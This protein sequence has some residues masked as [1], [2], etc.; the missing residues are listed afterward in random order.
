MIRFPIFTTVS[1][2]CMVDSLWE[3]STTVFPALS[4]FNDFR[5][6]P[7]LRGVQI[8]GGFVKEHQ[9]RIVKKSPWRCRSSAVRHRKEYPPA[10][11][12]PSHNLLRSVM[13]NSSTEA[14]LAASRISFMDAPELSDG[15]IGRDGNRETDGV[16]WV[17]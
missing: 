17:T 6:I 2:T 8:A 5:I 3:T 1:A 4:S 12:P 10:R 15:D 13:I 14:F 16:S 9:R 7:S 11:P